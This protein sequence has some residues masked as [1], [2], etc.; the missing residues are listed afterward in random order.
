MRTFIYFQGV[1]F[2]FF[3]TFLLTVGANTLFAQKNIT[4]NLDIE[5]TPLKYKGTPVAKKIDPMLLY[6]RDRYERG[7]QLDTDQLFH[8]KGNEILIK[9]IAETP[10]TAAKVIEQFK[11]IG[12]KYT[13]HYERVING[14][15]PFN[16]IEK[17][18]KFE[19][20]MNLTYS[21]RPV[22]KVGRVLSE[23][24]AAMN[25][26]IIKK[27]LGFDGTGV[28]IGILSDSYNSLGNAEEGVLSGDL[29]G[30]G[31]PNGYTT[32]VEVLL[33]F[34]FDGSDE[35]RGMAE[36]IHDV[37]PGAALSFYSASY[38]EGAFAQGIIA[39]RQ[40]A[41]C[42]I[43]V[44]D[45]VYTSEPFF[46]DGVIARAVNAVVN[47]GAVFFSSAGNYANHS[48]E[49]VFN[50]AGFEFNLGNFPLEPHVFPNGDI[51]QP[52]TLFPGESLSI[53]FQ[54]DEPFA[55]LSGFP[56]SR[57]DYNLVVFN[58]DLSEIVAISSSENLFKDPVE[59]LFL[60]N[61][62]TVA[63]NY[64]LLI[65]S[66]TPTLTTPNNLFKMVIMIGN[67][68][69]FGDLASEFNKATTYGHSNA[70]EAIAVGAAP[71]YFTPAFGFANPIP[72]NFTSLGG[73]PILFDEKG[74][75]LET[76]IVRDKPEITAPDGTNTTFFGNVDLED[77]GFP[78]FFG[79]SAA[80]P[81][82]AAA[83]ALIIQAYQENGR[84]TSPD[85]IKN[86]LQSTAIDIVPTTIDRVPAAISGLGIPL[87]LLQQINQLNDLAVGFD[88]LTGVGLIDIERALSDFADQIV[89]VDLSLTANTVGKVKRFAPNTLSFELTNSGDRAATGILVSIELP[90]STPLVGGAR[91]VASNGKYDI[92]TS[93]WSIPS[94]GVGESATL[95]L[96]IFP[97]I[98]DFEVFAQV[99]AFNELDID[100]R[101]ANGSCCI[102]IEDDE[103]VFRSSSVEATALGI[104]PDFDFI[105]TDATLMIESIYP[106][107]T[108][109]QTTVVFYS[110]LDKVNYTIQ[111]VHGRTLLTNQWSTE[112]GLNRK[113]IDLSGFAEGVYFLQID[114]ATPQRIIKLK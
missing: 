39:L 88:Y 96:Q 81:H 55:S 70:K 108:T 30:E 86:V 91:P 66:Y 33:D 112:Q 89:Y 29:P 82:A 95:N 51:F 87:N 35:G 94:L 54:W 2:A 38:G 74:N 106:N 45:V 113:S 12:L 58:E 97:L 28:K 60:E 7:E 44:D 63:R 111:D 67:P 100:S 105:P 17:A 99:L 46:Q 61:K 98:L 71:Y 64:N 110:Q 85:V 69:M 77:D 50:S 59:V 8:V 73:V 47:N 3:A 1:A 52:I 114:K 43:I 13:G 101:P 83:A 34:D 53:A 23:G 18:S 103:V 16:Q 57:T 79:T 22:L 24:D 27:G 48:Y 32:P 102:A 41:N 104:N 93:I 6:A 15:L 40:F 25:T 92:Y 62:D 9:A 20:L 26:D 5:L 11:S 72:E 68:L 31:N 76:P 90:K 36:L 4:L 75:R 37:A 49:A 65:G 78:N 56:G 109:N 14:F 19:H 107:P 84:S 10:E 42:D 80:A 21:P